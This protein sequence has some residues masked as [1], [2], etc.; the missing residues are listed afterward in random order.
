MLLKACSPSQPG[1]N[2]P[3][4]HPIILQ[5]TPL[6]MTCGPHWAAPTPR[7]LLM[8]PGTMRRSS[9]CLKLRMGA[10]QEF[11]RQPQ[12]SSFAFCLLDMFLLL[13]MQAHGLMI[14]RHIE[15]RCTQVHAY[16]LDICLSMHDRS[17]SCIT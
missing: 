1:S 5:M 15:A 2:P 13:H 3:K 16:A 12:G 8:L 10:G 6:M 14:R 17:H 7:V 9:S 11:W 4:Q